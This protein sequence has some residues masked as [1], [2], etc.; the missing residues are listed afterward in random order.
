M[1]QG[2]EMTKKKIL[3]I[4]LVL[5]I[6]SCAPNSTDASMVTPQAESEDSLIAMLPTILKPSSPQASY[7]E[8]GPPIPQEILKSYELGDYSFDEVSKM[9]HFIMSSVQTADLNQD[10]HIDLILGSEEHDSQIQVYENMGGGVFRNS[11]AIL[12]FKPRDPRHFN[13]GIAVGDLNQDDLPDIVAADAWS[14]LDIYLNTGNL[15][16][17][18]LQNYT[19]PKMVEDKGVAIAELYHDGYKDVVF[20][21]YGGGFYVLFND[22]TG[23]MVASGQPVDPGTAWS[24]FITDINR[25]GAPD[26]LSVNRQKED[27][28]LQPARIHI[29]DGDGFF[30]MASDIPDS[31]DDSYHILCEQG[32]KNTLCFI[33]NTEGNFH[34]PN[35]L[36][37][38]DAEGNLVENQGF[39]VVGA[40]TKSMC[41]ADINRDG[42]PDI[43]LGNYNWGSN[44]YFIKNNQGMLELTDPPM[45]LFNIE[46][47]S[48]MGCAD[49]NEDGLIDF[50]VGA[51]TQGHDVY[52]QYSILFQRPSK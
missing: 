15:K 6:T 22:G 7:V 48:N 28:S 39:G 19:H 16:F 47:T 35:R 37:N 36:L 13:F 1:D 29:N 38:F 43:V 46:R 32:D 51:E 49:L 34:R 24:L 30:K 12:P 31:A 2:D 44:V 45:Y 10:G 41:L 27:G 14:G 42:T 50:I 8:P 52:L 23:K 9:G 4:L 21:D 20:G 5:G 33:A 25:D 40:E 17:I 26:Y 11:G 3:V 18:Y